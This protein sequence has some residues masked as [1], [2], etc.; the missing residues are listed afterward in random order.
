M[1]VIAA[2]ATQRRTGERSYTETAYTGEDQRRP[3]TVGETSQ[4]ELRDFGQD[5]QDE[6]EDRAARRSHSGRAC[7]STRNMLTASTDP[8]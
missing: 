4:H 1:T 2:P 3:R 7:T 6:D 5:Y 8:R